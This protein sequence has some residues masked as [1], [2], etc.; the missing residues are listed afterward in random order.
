MAS[1]P[2]LPTQ[3]AEEAARKREVRLMKNRYI[4]CIYLDCC[5]LNV[6]S[7]S[8][9]CVSL[10][11]LVIGSLHWV[12]F[13]PAELMDL[14]KLYLMSCIYKIAIGLWVN[15]WSW[16]SFLSCSFPTGDLMHNLP[17]F[18]LQ[19]ACQVISKWFLFI[20]SIVQEDQ[21]FH[22]CILTVC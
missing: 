4:Y 11:L 6:S 1:S 17:M 5:G 2:A 13:F 10:H 9:G 3:P 7:L 19:P 12:F 22:I 21:E 14:A 18:A 15:L 20:Y 16:S 8:T